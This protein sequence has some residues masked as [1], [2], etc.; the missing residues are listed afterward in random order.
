MI[1][2]LAQFA[3]TQQNCVLPC[4]VLNSVRRVHVQKNKRKQKNLLVHW[5][6]MSEFPGCIDA[7]FPLTPS[8]Y[9]DCPRK[10]RPGDTKKYY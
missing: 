10:K 1:L 9:L 3:P 5:R 8:I 6:G 2:Y 7:A 4:T